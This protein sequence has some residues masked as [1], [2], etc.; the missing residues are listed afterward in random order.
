MKKEAKKL[1]AYYGCELRYSGKQRI[2]YVCGEESYAAL[3]NLRSQ[4]GN[5]IQFEI[6]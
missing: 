1:A 5:H 3:G 4:F 2:M 6:G